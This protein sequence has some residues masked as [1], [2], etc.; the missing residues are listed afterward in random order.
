MDAQLLAGLGAVVA[1]GVGAQWLA[2]RLHLPSILLLLICGL[3]AGPAFDLL[4]PDELFGDILFPLVSLGVAIILFEGGLSLR[5]ADLREIGAVIRNLMT[6]GVAVSWALG[7]A[8]GHFIAGLSWPLAVLLGAVLVVT[9]PTVIIPLLR[10]VRPIGQ[11]GRIVKWEG[12]VNDP[13]GAILAVLVFEAI[14][15]GGFP[16]VTV[17]AAEGLLVTLLWGSGLGTLGAVLLVAILRWHAAPDFLHSPIAFMAVVGVFVVSNLA[18]HESGLLA[19]TLMG[20]LLANQKIVAVKHII[21]FKENLRVL[22]IS[23]LFILL[24]ARITLEDLHQIDAESVFFILFLILVARPLSVAVATINVG[25]DWRERL[26]LA[27]MAP[28]GIVAAAVSAVFAIKLEATGLAQAGELVPLVFLV[29]VVTVVVYGTTAAP[30]ARFLGL[31]QPHPQGVLIVGANRVGIEF[32]RALGEQHIKVLL[33]DT[34]WANV[35]A[36]RMRG[37]PAHYGSGLAENIADELDLDGVGRVL[38]MTP[39]DEANSLTA[40]HF[41]EVFG[42]SEVYQLPPE[43]VD[44][45][46]ESRFSPLHLRGRFLFDPQANAAYL[47]RRLESGA[48]LKT[49]D[50]TDSFDFEEFK[51]LYGTDALPLFSISSSGQLRVLNSEDDNDLD[52]GQ[53]LISLVDIP[54]GA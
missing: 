45:G 22:L 49:T 38:A 9:G 51:K 40:L 52:S 50:L 16:A 4:H 37:L 18:Q 2:W 32:A 14:L 23:S 34:N 28:R 24:A 3:A 17:I 1:L 36:A 21:D 25:L 43:S 6:L 44:E 53:S 13:I 19:V 12:I 41:S 10:Q 42:R 29:I 35:R 8:G 48:V 31:A 20:I 27:W 54:A 33:L 39:N 26:F 30:L 5:L 15:L 11:I 7:A 47:L 46:E